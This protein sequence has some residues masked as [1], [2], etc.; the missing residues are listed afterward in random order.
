M[1]HA[2]PERHPAACRDGPGARDHRQRRSILKP[3]S[4]STAPA[5]ASPW[6][7]AGTPQ[8]FAPGLYLVATPIG[9]LR[10]ITLR[11]L[12]LLSVA[13]RI[14]CEDTRVTAKL[15]QHYGISRPTTSYHEHNAERM[16]PRVMEHLAAGETVALVSDAGTPLVSDPGYRLVRAAVERGLMVT[17]LPGPSAALA[18]LSVAGLPTDRFLFAGFP[19]QKSAARRRFFEEFR[20][21]SATLIFYESPHRLQPS[22]KD[23]A[24]TLGDRPAAICRE[25]TKKFEEVRR[26]TLGAL[27]RIYGE[28]ESVKGEI[29]LIVGPPGDPAPAEE[30]DI[31]AL[32]RDAMSR[33]SLKEAAAAVAAATGAPKRAVYARALALKEGA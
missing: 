28:E 11:A 1:T 6:R 19:P 5:E 14:L 12:D 30:A 16:L 22:L 10:D 8:Q 15:L 25:L 17:A 18:A 7:D 24:E 29:V 4:H 3:S 23:A 33:L 27:A 26:G 2:T 20:A 13:D 31:D 21:T 32:L 9:N